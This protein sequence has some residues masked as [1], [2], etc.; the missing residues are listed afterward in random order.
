MP[1]QADRM[2]REVYAKQ[3]SLRRAQAGRNSFWSSI[4]ILGVIGWSVVLPSLG[5]ILLGAWLDHRWPGRVSWALTL[6]AAGLAFGCMTA[7]GR[8][9]GD[10]R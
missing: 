7:W 6:F 2:L 1:D 5:G 3:Q 10:H 9:K 4:G 8:I